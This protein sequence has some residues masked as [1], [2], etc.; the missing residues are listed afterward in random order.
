MSQI[1]VVV[2]SL[3]YTL[4]GI[5]AFVS[6]HQNC[7]L[8]RLKGTLLFTASVDDQNAACLDGR[9]I[10]TQR[11]ETAGAVSTLLLIKLCGIAASLISIMGV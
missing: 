5:K 9:V 11:I 6:P 8:F 2:S 3:F 1:C 4:L 7:M 10:P